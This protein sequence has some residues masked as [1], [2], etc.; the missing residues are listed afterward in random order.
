LAPLLLRFEERRRH[1]KFLGSSRP[2]Q[3]SGTVTAIR[4]TSTLAVATA[5]L[6]AATATA[7][8]TGFAASGAGG[9]PTSSSCDVV[10]TGADGFYWAVSPDGK[11]RRRL[12]RLSKVAGGAVGIAGGV[13]YSPDGKTVAFSNDNGVS[14]LDSTGRVRSV[15]VG[16]P[17]ALVYGP[18]WASDGRRIAVTVED[19]P[20]EVSRIYLVGADYR[21][22]L[23][24]RL[25]GSID[26]PSWSP[27]GRRL[28]F[29]Y[30]KRGS[31][32]HRLYTINS[33]GGGLRM[34]R[35]PVDD[36][37][38]PAW[39][40]DGQHI[41]FDSL[42]HGAPFGGAIYVVNLDG[43][44]LRKLRGTDY[45]GDPLWSP[46]S[47]YI[48]FDEGTDPPYDVYVINAKGGNAHS[49]TGPLLST[50]QAD[51]GDTLDTWW[52]RP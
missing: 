31:F 37:D 42:S 35:V 41:A 26:G 23:L 34:L 18:R 48:A 28:V 4:A 25:N 15:S 19:G 17:S 3:T 47:R 52:C 20:P 1:D 21:S 11:Q 22:R 49:V 44:G 29:E 39:A 14:I 9:T 27:D 45:G 7:T 2:Q 5:A 30:N 12:D 6:V 16:R 33:D 51:L 50:S 43:S 10:Y 38:H 32:H 40:P 24:L 36:A 13:A 8:S 46:D